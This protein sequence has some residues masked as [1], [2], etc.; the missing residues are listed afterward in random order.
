M[1]HAQQTVLELP[2]TPMPR[3]DERVDAPEAD[4]E[5][6]DRD[7]SARRSH[8]LCGFGASA[9][10]ATS[11]VIARNV[12]RA[13]PGSSGLL[14]PCS[15]R[16]TLDRPCAAGHLGVRVAD[17][18]EVAVARLGVHLGQQRVAAR[19]SSCSF[20]TRLSGSCRSPNTIA[21][22]GH[23]IWHAV[24]ISPS[25]SG[26]STSPARVPLRISA[27][28]WI[29]RVLDALHAERALLHH[30]AHAHR[31]V[32]VEQQAGGPCRAPRGTP[33]SSRGS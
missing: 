10:H 24:S 20:A 9:I 7:A 25:G 30:A 19:R 27:F 3:H 2:Q 11:R 16:T 13:L 12:S 28:A 23:A 17:A 4:A 21:S 33:C 18:R 6:D 15:F 32:R 8:S 5:H 1:S 26:A 29:L 22:V 31:D 14:L